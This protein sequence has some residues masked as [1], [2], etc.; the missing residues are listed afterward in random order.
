MKE[1]VKTIEKDGI[2]I[3]IHRHYTVEMEVKGKA[4]TAGEAQTLGD[5][6]ILAEQC[7]DE[8]K[9]MKKA[10]YGKA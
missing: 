8:Y 6:E 7:I 2:K 9:K 1:K 5:A 4:W 3:T 10:W